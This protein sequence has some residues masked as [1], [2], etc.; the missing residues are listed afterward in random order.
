MTADRAIRVI[1]EAPERDRLVRA[2]KEA[3]QKYQWHRTAETLMRVYQEAADAPAVDVDS[4]RV[5][6]L[7]ETAPAPNGRMAVRLMAKTLSWWQA[8]GLARGSWLGGR[9]LARKVAGRVRGRLHARH[10]TSS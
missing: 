7:A 1:R 4:A 5:M 9:A 2:V 3:S 6:F 8:Y 10:M